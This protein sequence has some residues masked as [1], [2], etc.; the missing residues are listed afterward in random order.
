M[1]KL[2]KLLAAGLVLSLLT[3]CSSGKE[4]TLDLSFGPRTGTYTGEMKD[5]LPN[6]EGKFTTKNEEGTKWTYE[7]EFKDGHFEGEGKETWEDGTV[8]I[9]TFKNDEVV[10]MEGS[11]INGWESNDDLVDHMIKAKAKV[12]VDPEP[13]EDQYFVQAYP[14]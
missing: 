9:G 12:F 5:N 6:G 10:P 7:G 2:K 14:I 8:L 11:E 13:I 3:G 4:I 1:L